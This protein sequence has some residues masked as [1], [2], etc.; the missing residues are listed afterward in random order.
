MMEE[1]RAV[2]AAVKKLAERNGRASSPS[3]GKTHVS[4]Q[5][6]VASVK[7]ASVQAGQTFASTVKAGG[8]P[9]MAGEASV[10]E[11]TAMPVAAV[12]AAAGAPEATPAATAATIAAAPTAPAAPAAPAAAVPKAAK[13]TPTR[14]SQ[15]EKRQRSSPEEQNATKRGKTEDGR[16]NVEPTEGDGFTLVNHRKAKATVPKASTVITVGKQPEPLPAKVH[17]AR[18]KPDAMIVKAKEDDKYDEIYASLCDEPKLQEFGKLVASVGRT[19]AGFLKI[20]LREGAKSALHLAAVQQVLGAA[21]EVRAVS[22]HM[23][24]ECRGLYQ[25]TTEAMVQNAL[26]AEFGIVQPPAVTVRRFRY[27]TVAEIQLP[28]DT[29]EK[30]IRAGQ[31]RVGWNDCT[32]KALPNPTRCFRCWEFGHHA[33]NCKGEDRSA[34][35]KRCSTAGHSTAACTA[36]PSCFMCPSGRN[37]HAPGSFRCG[38][39]QAACR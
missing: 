13:N 35:C 33:R 26:K 32:L 16:G 23:T 12:A 3:D 15:G 28:V 5:T 21:V 38:A 4:C 29:A 30:L 25:Q 39:R 19:S 14:G 37:S 11:V 2:K 6:S 18:F 36:K 8:Q 24:V 27:K 17:Q 22:P 10:S 20:E 1:L 7:H 34:V 9:T 31:M